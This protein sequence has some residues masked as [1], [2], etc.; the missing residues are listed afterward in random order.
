M[1]DIERM[2][3]R[4]DGRGRL[5]LTKQQLAPPALT[6]KLGGAGLHD[7]TASNA[8]KH[9]LAARLHA[10]HRRDVRPYPA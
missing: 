5:I 6:R 9:Q 7:D 10:H 8:P 1:L 2:E 4:S 3:L